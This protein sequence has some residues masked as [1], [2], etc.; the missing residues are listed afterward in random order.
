MD[1]K[2]NLIKK[3]KRRPKLIPDFVSLFFF[4]GKKTITKYYNFA[5]GCDYN[6]GDVDQYDI[7]KLFGFTFN[8]LPSI[9]NMLA[10]FH[11]NSCRLGWR[12]I[13]NK[14]EILPYEYINSER[15]MR[16]PIAELDLNKWYE[17]EIVIDKT[18]VT[19]NIYDGDVVLVSYNT[20]IEKV[21]FFGH[22]MGLY[23][24]GNEVAPN[25]IYIFE[26]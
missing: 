20:H 2:I 1:Y 10:P 14:M 18:N 21:S 8:T 7:N 26:R 12:F 15:I 24:G 13:N 25:D 11:I 16:S 23:F 3:G 4:F 5:T 6:L 22:Y 19:Y 9:T 17:F